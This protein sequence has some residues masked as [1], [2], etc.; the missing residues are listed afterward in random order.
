MFSQTVGI[1]VSPGNVTELD[2][3]LWYKVDLG[4]SGI[5]VTHTNDYVGD[6]SFVNVRSGDYHIQEDSAARDKGV[7]VFVY[8]DMDGQ[9]RPE[10]KRHDI[11][12]DEFWLLYRVFLP[13]T[14]RGG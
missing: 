13:L 7:D 12:A 11:G 3:T 6:P 4:I 9:L 10:G 5:G 14:L 1:K 2:A 8:T